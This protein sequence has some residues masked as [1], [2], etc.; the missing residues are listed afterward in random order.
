VSGFDCDIDDE[1]F[2]PWEPGQGRECG[3]CSL[4]CKVFPIKEISKPKDTWCP[5]CR[6]SGKGGCTI[7]NSR[8]QI[9]RAYRCAWLGWGDMGDEWFPAHCKM[10]MDCEGGGIRVTV[11]P[12]FPD[13]WRREP[14]YSQLLEFTNVQIRIGLLSI[15]PHTECITFLKEE[16]DTC[17]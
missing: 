11:D 17:A 3:E 10:V 6:P 8:P 12:D 15:D 4:C 7:Y 1:E 5:H 16:S 2:I 13:A 14:Y 9:C